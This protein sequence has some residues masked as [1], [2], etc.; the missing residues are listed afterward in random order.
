VKMTASR[1]RF[2][3]L[4]TDKIAAAGFPMPT[5]QDAVARWLAARNVGSSRTNA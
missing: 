1:P 2:C 4:S 3:A 5:W